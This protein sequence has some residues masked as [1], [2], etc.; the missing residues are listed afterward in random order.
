MRLPAGAS[1]ETLLLVARDLVGVDRD[2]EALVLQGLRGLIDRHAR[3]VRHG[4][5]RRLDEVRIRIREVVT[6]ELRVR[7]GLVGP[8]EGIAKLCELGAVRCIRAEEVALVRLTVAVLT[9]HVLAVLPEQAPV[10]I[11]F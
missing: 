9:V 3:D 8:R 5:L 1:P 2:V 11:G 6:A 10:V 4:V 7:G